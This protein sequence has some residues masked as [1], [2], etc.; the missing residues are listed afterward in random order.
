VML[1]YGAGL[2]VSEIARL[3]IGVVVEIHGPIKELV[4]PHRG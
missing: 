1:A 3:E 4:D 2:R